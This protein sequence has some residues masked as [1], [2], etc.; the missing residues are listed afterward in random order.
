[1]AQ[2]Q[3]PMPDSI[4][5]ALQL[6][7][8]SFRGYTAQGIT[9]TLQFKFSGPEPGNWI[10]RVADGKCTV[11]EGEIEDASVTVDA[12]SD[13]WLKILRRELDGTAAFMSGQFTCAGDI[14]VL[15]DMQ[16]W[17]GLV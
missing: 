8:T 10:M 6:A 14:T 5:E 16:R 12:P 9:A 13:V 11:E 1:M 2:D 15:V 17:F 4:R 7:P 3:L